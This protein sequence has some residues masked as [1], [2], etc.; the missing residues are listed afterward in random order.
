MCILHVNA[1]PNPLEPTADARARPD[2]S[3]DVTSA[4]PL[5]RSARTRRRAHP[6]KNIT[7]HALHPPTRDRARMFGSTYSVHA[8]V[9][10]CACVRHTLS[11]IRSNVC[12]LPS[13]ITRPDR[14]VL[15]AAPRASRSRES[16]MHACM[17]GIAFHPSAGRFLLQRLREARNRERRIQL[18]QAGEHR[19][20]HRRHAD[21]HRDD[22]DEVVR[23]CLFRFRF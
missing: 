19:K 16:G 21:A 1:E 13:R 5:H 15:R 12:Q 8:A 22:A 6:E 11:S 20:D 18:E 2:G 3:R 14:A 4:A 9:I 17:H 7:D 10:V 23:L